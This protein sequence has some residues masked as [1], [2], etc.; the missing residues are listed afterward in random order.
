MLINGFQEG[1]AA[2]SKIGYGLTSL[3]YLLSSGKHIFRSSVVAKYAQLP[4]CSWV[5]EG[6]V[7]LPFSF[8]VKYL[9]KEND[10][11]FSNEV[12]CAFRN[13]RNTCVWDAEVGFVRL[14]SMTHRE[15]GLRSLSEGMFEL[16][17]LSVDPGSKGNL[18]LGLCWEGLGPDQY[19]TV[20]GTTLSELK[21]CEGEKW[22]LSNKALGVQLSK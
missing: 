13:R 7:F 6:E 9:G 8:L 10:D 17:S 14:L 11:I 3:K 16:G 18:S 21:H 22:G 1:L 15:A 4:L 2:D 20:L 5:T 19:R 12:Q